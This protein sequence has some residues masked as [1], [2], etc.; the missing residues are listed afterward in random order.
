MLLILLALT[1]CGKPGIPGSEEER[2]PVPAEDVAR[3]LSVLPVG[4]EQIREVRDAVTASADNGYDEEYMLRDLFRE[5]G[6]GVGSASSAAPSRSGADARGAYSEPL[7]DLIEAHV[8]S[9]AVTRAGGR[10]ADEY[11]D[12]LRRSDVQIYWPYSDRTGDSEEGP[13]ITFDP[14]DGSDVNVGWRSVIGADGVRTVEE[15]MVDEDYARA[16]P[17]WVVNRNNDSAYKSLELMRREDPDWGLSGGGDILVG[18]LRSG[19]RPAAERIGG[20]KMRTLVLKSLTMKRQFDPWFA[21]A[22]EFFVKLGALDEFRASTEAEL[23]L[24]EP[25]VTDFMIV[26]RRSMIGQPRPFNAVLVS[27]WT[28]QLQT[29]AFMIIEDDGGTRTSW[30]AEGEVK[31]KSKTYGFGVTL[32]YRTRDDIVWRGNLSARYFERYSNVTGHFG[33]VDLVFEVVER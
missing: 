27:D 20:K 4:Q 28:D 2:T 33:D 14:D 11:L 18:P 17:V 15:I 9:G 12:A 10:T 24:Y 30:K 6:A 31:I 16:H 7:R 13:V 19:L 29:C 8:R 5:P 26:V 22:S 3:L 32:P 21:G 23:L 25:T 1:A